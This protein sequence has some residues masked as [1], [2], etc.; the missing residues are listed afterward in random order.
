MTDSHDSLAGILANIR[1]FRDERDW[2]QF[3]T[4]QQLAAA[5]SIEAGE[6]QEIFLWKDGEEATSALQEPHTLRDASFEI[7]DVLIYA[8]LFCDA[9][10]IDPAESIEAKLELNAKKYPVERSKGRSKKYTELEG[11]EEF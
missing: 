5:L 2:A 8:L 1:A 11:C 4:P 7:A 3:H 9:I 10:G 6:L